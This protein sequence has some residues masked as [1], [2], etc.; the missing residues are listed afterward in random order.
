MRKLISLVLVGLILMTGIACG[1][2]EDA[3][4][5]F[6]VPMSEM[7]DDLLILANSRQPLNAD[8]VPKDLE[9][10]RTRHNNAS[11]EADNNGIY[12]ATNTKIQMNRTALNALKNLFAAAESDGVILYIRTGYRSWNELERRYTHPQQGD[13]NAPKPGETDYQTGLAATVVGR[14]TRGGTLNAAS[15]DA[16]IE[17]Q[18]LKRN[19]AKYGFI[20]RYP[21]NGESSTGCAYEP[22]HLRFVGKAVAQ[23]I[24][25]NDL[26]LEE[27]IDQREAAYDRFV[28]NG[29]DLNAAMASSQ[30]P[31]GAIQLEEQGPDGDYEIVLFHD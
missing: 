15:F 11:G 8:F 25:K 22:W 13:V 21:E 17:G 20:V 27:F 31:A 6:P 23:Y 10:V 9:T 1:M 14:D 3:A 18:W 24:T 2:A 30:L 26:T 5:D 4:W 28:A 16:T 19:A 7:R 29:G 12:T